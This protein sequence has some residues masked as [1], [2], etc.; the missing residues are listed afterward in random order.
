MGGLASSPRGVVDNIFGG[1]GSI[2][3]IM[4]SQYAHRHSPDDDPGEYCFATT[5][6][7]YLF[8][9]QFSS[10]LFSLDEGFVR[11]VHLVAEPGVA[12]DIFVCRCVLFRKPEPRLGWRW[13]A[14][15]TDI[16]WSQ[17]SEERRPDHGEVGWQREHS[18]PV[19]EF[20]L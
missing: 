4:T 17:T 8:T 13:Q 12:V 3:N 5:S 10:Q 19:S 20:V 2:M 16:R 6:L 9:S 18:G 7:P 1:M 11:C 14:A 15:V